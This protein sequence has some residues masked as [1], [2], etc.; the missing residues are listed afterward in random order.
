MLPKSL[1]ETITSI[2]IDKNKKILRK[3]LLKSFLEIYPDNQIK[4]NNLEISETWSVKNPKLI[5]LV[6]PFIVTP[7]PGIWTKS[8]IIKDNNKKYF[9]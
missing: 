4:K 1:W 9:P 3:L 7:R 2:S 8:E 5:H 6:A